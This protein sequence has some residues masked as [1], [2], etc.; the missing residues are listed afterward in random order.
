MDAHGKVHFLSVSLIVLDAPSAILLLC[1]TGVEFRLC[2]A[3]S[4]NMHR[5]ALVCI[6]K[7][8]Q[9]RVLKRR[10]VQILLLLAR[11]RVLIRL[12]LQVLRL[13]RLRL[14]KLL[15][16]QHQ[17]NKLAQLLWSK[18]SVRLLLSLQSNGISINSNIIISII[19]SI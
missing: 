15:H 12:G 2:I 4:R 6:L 9:Q 7:C 3:K 14:L 13:L 17:H 18:V 11:A 8:S 16:L 10:L 5:V 1:A 19:N